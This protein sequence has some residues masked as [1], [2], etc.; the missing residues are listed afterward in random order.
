MT[1]AIPASIRNNNPGAMYPGPSATKFGAVKTNKIGGGHLIAQFPD[2][3]SGAAALFDLLNRAYA[4]MTV[5]GAIAKWSGGNNVETYVDVV[6]AATGL[7]PLDVITVPYLQTARTA[8]KLACAMARHEAGQ[9]FPL[10][11]SEWKS[12]HKLAF[13]HF[14]IPAADGEK[15]AK[16]LGDRIA[17][18]ARGYIGVRETPGPECTQ[19]IADWY[20]LLGLARRDDS[21]TP[22]CRLFA[23][24]VWRLGGAK[25][26]APDDPLI[27]LARDHLKLG[28]PVAK[29]EDLRPGDA[30]VWPRGAPP[31]GHIGVVIGVDHDDMEVEYAEGNLSNKVVAKRYTFEQIDA[32]AIGSVRPE[33]DK[34]RPNGTKT[35]RDTASDSPSLKMQLYA[36]LAT[37][38]ATVATWWEQVT[39][40][41]SSVVNALPF[42]AQ[43]T[44]T[45]VG[46]V[47]ESAEQATGMP[48]SAKL[49]ILVAVVAF[50]TM[51]FRQ[52]RQKS[53]RV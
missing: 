31:S 52:F 49:L 3:V 39:S 42:V 41:A 33:A 15:P 29:A 44:S 36:Y 1:E 19:T 18:I 27:L 51:T 9:E 24:A 11:K 17:A 12:A 34:R 35:L 25:V 7:K 4:G 32:R 2:P 50:V 20:E 16:A 37:A 26:P 38:G 5:R 48:L 8:I 45:T 23:N 46:K 28:T 53:G 30:T 10:T 6:C 43:D 14:T 13:K 40:G 21:T 22:W 47:R